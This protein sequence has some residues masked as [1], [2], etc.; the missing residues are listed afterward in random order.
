MTYPKIGLKLNLGSGQRPFAD[1]WI[2]VD[3]QERWKPDIVS[4]AASL[5][6]LADG[7]CDLI[8]LHH[9][10]E[11]YGC[12]EAAGLLQ[13]CRR[14]LAPGGSLLVFVP[15]MKA[16]AL[17]YLEGRLST[18]VYMTSVYGAYMQ[19]EADRHKW[20]YDRQSLGYFLL[21]QGFRSCRTFDWR[22][23]TGADIAR[24]DS[25]ILGMEAIK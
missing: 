1:P 10:L 15:D 6:M 18:Q 8:V 3:K 14:L 13:E 16:L 4:D 23:I 22:Y 11:H 25:W 20:G 7:S 5:P 19:D 21:G 2:N 17:M 9:V 24:D 12:G